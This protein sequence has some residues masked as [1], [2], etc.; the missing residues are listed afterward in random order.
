ML[1][2]Q[3]ETLHVK[4]V[5]TTM[6][7]SFEL[8]PMFLTQDILTILYYNQLVYLTLSLAFCNLGKLT[9]NQDHEKTSYYT[10]LRCIRHAVCPGNNIL[11]Y[12]EY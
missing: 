12:S 2:E 8:L 1:F 7:N 6:S 4:N 9:Q 3:I 10:F 5:E 11:L